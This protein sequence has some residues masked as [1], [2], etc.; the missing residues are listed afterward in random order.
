MNV[1]FVD[2]ICRFEP[3]ALE[4]GFNRTLGDSPLAKLGRKRKYWDMY[5]VLYPIMTEHGDGGMPQL[6]AEEFVRAYEQCVQEYGRFTSAETRR[7][8]LDVLQNPALRH[9]GEAANDE[10]AAPD[11]PDAGQEQGQ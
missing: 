10:N 4:K 11:L 1:A 2:F 7:Q 9:P 6:F 5:S 8:T 3:A